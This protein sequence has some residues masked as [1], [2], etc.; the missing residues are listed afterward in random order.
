MNL[1]LFVSKRQIQI[2]MLFTVDGRIKVCLDL[3][4]DKSSVVVKGPFFS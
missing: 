1:L 4:A 3:Q 2:C